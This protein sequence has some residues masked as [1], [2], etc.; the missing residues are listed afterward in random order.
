MIQVHVLTEGFV[1]PNGRAFLFPLIFHRRALREAGIRL[2]YFVAVCEALYDCDVLA[3]DSKFYSSG[4]QAHS[5]SILDE[6][7]GFREK[8]DK[9]VYFDIGDSSGWDHA[10]VL[11]FVTLY[12]KNQVLKDRSLYLRPIYGYRLHADYYY[13]QCGIEDDCADRSEP[14]ADP[15]Q[16]DKLTVSWNSGL[17]DYSW[18]GPAR[19]AL[20]QHIQLPALLRAPT[21]FVAP[22]PDRPQ[23]ISCRIGTNYPRKTV[24]WQRIAMRQKLADRMSTVKTSR[25]NYLREIEQ[26][27]LVV[28]PFGYGEITLRDFEVFRAGAVLLKPDMSHME[29]WPDL[30]RAGETMVVHRWD[31]SDL[32]D[33]IDDVLSNYSRNLDLARN[34]QNIYRRHLVGD[35][36]ATLFVGHLENLLRLAERMTARP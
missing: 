19:M 36:A 27:K 16:L 7:A 24:A 2:R 30:F 28:S 20:Y 33:R 15:R 29:T 18:L 25:R 8:L 31:L 35:E 17:A 21:R 9:V 14:V 11:P 6:I 23:D 4:W 1:S 34:A 26:S 22:S 13:Q 10:R 32:E 12:C 5:Q 3:V